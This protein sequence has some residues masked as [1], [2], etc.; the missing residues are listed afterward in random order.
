MINMKE[1]SCKKNKTSSILIFSAYIPPHT[2]GI[3][4]YVDNLAK[5]LVK[6]HYTPVIITANHDDLPAQEKI[7]GVQIFRLPIFSLFKNRYPIPKS[8]KLPQ[9]LLEQLSKYDVQV[10][11]VNARFY[12]TSQIG[13]KYGQQHGIPVYLIEHGSSYV[14]LGNLVID[15]FANRYEDF[16]TKQIKSKI[17]G[18][19]GVSEACNTWLRKIGIS[20]SGVWYNSIDCG[21]PPMPQPH[22]GVNFLYAGRILKQKGVQNILEA[23]T[24]LQEKHTQ[25]DIN[26]YIA[27]DGPDLIAYKKQY[28]N[29][30]V[31]FL[32]HLNPHELRQCY[33]LCDVFLFPSQ[34]PEGLPTA[35][36]EAGLAQCAVIGTDRGGTMEVI[37]DGKSGII[38]EPTTDALLKAME[39]L[40]DDKELRSRLANALFRTIQQDFSWQNTVQKI[41]NDIKKPNN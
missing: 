16:L 28:Q 33:S 24:Q 39:Q 31:H 3:E 38:I 40:L 10:I 11:I 22:S 25:N 23:F 14:S 15:F 9:W 18:F 7:N 20:P 26:L 13:A 35:I 29:P 4:R 6:H 21:Q 27:G 12:L 8:H 36:L 17:A 32:G 41:L 19:Y 1:S 30:K 34:Y 2:G 5:E 37:Q